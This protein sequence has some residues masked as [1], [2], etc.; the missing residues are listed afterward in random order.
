MGGGA[1]SPRDVTA[2]EL[3]RMA[4]ELGD[5]AAEVLLK[6]LVWPQV[7]FKHPLK[8]RWQT[9]LRSP[10]LVARDSQ[11]YLELTGSGLAEEAG[12]P[13]YLPDCVRIQATSL[14]Q[15]VARVYYVSHKAV[16]RWLERDNW[17]WEKS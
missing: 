2:S 17:P 12:H 14:G 13:G 15:A 6:S 7:Y 8:T 11:V 16:D 5:E 10:Q 3:M 9:E 4:S 1:V